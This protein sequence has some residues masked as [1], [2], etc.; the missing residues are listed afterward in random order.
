MT[1]PIG[2]RSASVAYE[3]H[4]EPEAT[5]LL[6][7]RI[8]ALI[9]A[10]PYLDQLEERLLRS[11]GTRLFDWVD[12][13]HVWT[14]TDLAASGFLPGSGD[15]QGR[16]YHPKATL[17]YVVN[18]GRSLIY[19]RADR[20]ASTLLALGNDRQATIHGSPTASLRWATLYQDAEIE[21]RV[22]ERH[23]DVRDPESGNFTVAD[24]AEL[25]R[26]TEALLLRPRNLGDE[27]DSFQHAQSLIRE[28][29]EALG[30]DRT[31]ELFFETERAYW[32]SRNDAAQVQKFRQD[33]FGLGWANHDHHTYRSSREHYADLI[34]TL[35]LLGMTCRERFYAGV[36][37]GWGAQVLEQPAARIVVFADVDMA[38]EELHGDFAHGILEPR[39][40]LGTVGIWV[41]LHGEAILQ[42]GMHHLECQFSFD[43]AR[44]QLSQS[45]VRAMSPFTNY[46]YLRQA[47]TEG[48]RWPVSEDRIHR[49]LAR[50]W[51]SQGEADTFRKHG[52]IGSHLEILER[53]DGYKGFN[54]TGVSDIIRRTDARLQAATTGS[55]SHK[56]VPVAP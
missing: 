45:G 19:L 8:Q 22:I 3:W 25:A 41:A 17:P 55:G 35:E 38:P 7:G 21:V 36:E 10:C 11:C 30:V 53:N 44:A 27:R 5:N 2:D 14:D 24:S 54:Q 28:A 34:Q 43:A 23:G 4:P 13:L 20:V 32:Q 12:T 18:D 15:L 39:D 26:V 33:R 46:R 47:F 49:A 31:C 50:G 16:W 42:A 48:Q 40:Q 29:I 6:A 51:I 52:A 9:L 56:A 1:A 37:A